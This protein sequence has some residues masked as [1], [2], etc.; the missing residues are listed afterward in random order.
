MTLAAS[1]LI[2][3]AESIRVFP[4]RANCGCR[5]LM[6]TWAE[7]AHQGNEHV[8]RLLLTEQITACVSEPL[9]RQQR[10]Q[11][12]PDNHA[13]RQQGTTQA[14][15]EVRTSMTSTGWERGEDVCGVSSVKVPAEGSGWDE[16]TW[17]TGRVK[18][19]RSP[20]AAAGAP[21]WLVSLSTALALCSSSCFR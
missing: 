5:R 4:L 13:R 11:P 6:F 20:K 7:C 1:S 12:D 16:P 15:L 21:A 8:H 9:L 19:R 3:V 14:E 2:L 10:A 17:Q 18:H